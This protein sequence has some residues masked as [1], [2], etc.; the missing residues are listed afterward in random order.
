M[1]SNGFLPELDGVILLL[2]TQYTSVA[3]RTQP[4]LDLI[5]KTP[6]CWLSL[7]WKLIPRLLR[8]KS[9]HRTLPNGP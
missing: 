7:C 1:N 9:Y 3:G 4:K 2:K 8:E 5:Y 6:P